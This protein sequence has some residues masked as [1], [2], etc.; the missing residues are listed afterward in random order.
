MLEAV[1]QF[2]HERKSFRMLFPRIF[3]VS[4]HLLGHWST[5]ECV[6]KKKKSCSV[7]L[8]LLKAVQLPLFFIFHSESQRPFCQPET[9]TALLYYAV[10]VGEIL[11]P[12]V[13]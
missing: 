7:R 8:L 4:F 9:S 6:K 10:T 1:S 3:A 12:S 2:H 5:V 13:C 11:G